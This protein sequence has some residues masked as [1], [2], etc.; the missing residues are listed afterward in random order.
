M[1]KIALAL[2]LLLLSA[3]AFAQKPD[4]K[5]IKTE[6][7]APG[8][9]HYYPKLFGRYFEGDTTL[10]RLDYHYLYYGFAFQPEYDPLAEYTLEG[11][12][13]ENAAEP[14]EADCHKLITMARQRL[15]KDP[16][17]PRYLNLLSFAYAQT[18]NDDLAARY[19][20][21]YNGV[22][23]AILSSGDGLSDKSPFHCIAPSHRDDVITALGYKAREAITVD[24][25]LEYVPLDDN[26]VKGIYFDYSRFYS[27]RHHTRKQMVQ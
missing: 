2:P 9:R 6:I 7:A 11:V 14:T 8:S 25:S 27:P 17:S 15:A 21:R 23:Q 3:A 26:S 12:R 10:D 4:N 16:F 5:Q 20:A 24:N 22:M 13:L 1:K 18:G 19:A